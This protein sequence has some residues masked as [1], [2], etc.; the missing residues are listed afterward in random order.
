VVLKEI[1]IMIPSRVDPTAERMSQT[2]LES[3]PSKQCSLLRPRK[4]R[5]RIFLL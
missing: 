3:T 1:F 5:K 2:Q 4:D